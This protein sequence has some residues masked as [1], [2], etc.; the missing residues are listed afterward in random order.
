MLVEASKS[1]NQGRSLPSFLSRGTWVTIRPSSG[2]K[3][4]P[5]RRSLV[6]TLNK[7]PSANNLPVTQSLPESSTTY[8][9]PQVS[10]STTCHKI[11][12]PAQRPHTSADK[13]LNCFAHLTFL[14]RLLESLLLHSIYDSYKTAGA[15]L[16][17][18]EQEI[19]S[20]TT[21]PVATHY[22]KPIRTFRR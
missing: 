21:H 22:R 7:S 6:Q 1:Q 15:R 16:T 4:A 2:V 5:S 18:I 11:N 8:R 19:R 12:A 14:A 10:S 13:F 9:E 3:V 17:I 20:L